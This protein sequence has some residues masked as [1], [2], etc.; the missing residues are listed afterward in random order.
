MKPN[1]SCFGRIQLILFIRGHSKISSKLDIS[2][3][4]SKKNCDSRI[5]F[6]DIF[7]HF[8]AF[9][10]IIWWLVKSGRKWSKSHTWGSKVVLLGKRKSIQS[11]IFKLMLSNGGVESSLISHSCSW[12]VLLSQVLCQGPCPVTCW[13]LNPAL[14]SVLS[15]SDL[16]L[17]PFR[18][19]EC[20]LVLGSHI[21][22]FVSITQL[23][24]KTHQLRSNKRLSGQ[25]LHKS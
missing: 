20:L 3:Y 25:N 9:L 14:S 6:F 4:V 2:C 24:P 17:G 1:F 5:S 8:S 12:S 23:R 21:P 15:Q 18:L 19:S 7:R 16:V 11:N 22:I 10:N 13:C